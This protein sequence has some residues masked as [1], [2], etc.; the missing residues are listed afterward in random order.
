MLILALLALLAQQAFAG[1]ISKWKD[2]S[3]RVHYGDTPPADVAAERLS[4]D[5]NVY[6]SQT[7]E[8]GLEPAPAAIATPKPKKVVMYSTA[9]CGYCRKARAYFRANG[10][11]FT[12]YDVETSDKGRRDYRRMGA[13]GVPVILVGDKRMMG[14]SESAFASLYAGDQ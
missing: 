1:E 8:R 5:P 13:R 7:G 14:F 9:R 10:I 12:D 11:A 6:E 4:V 2:A 3:G